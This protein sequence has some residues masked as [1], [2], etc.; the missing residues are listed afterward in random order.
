MDIYAC[1]VSERGTV[2]SISSCLRT[3]LKAQCAGAIDWR[4]DL[5]HRPVKSMHRPLYVRIPA[6]SL[7]ST[8][9]LIN[10][11]VILRTYSFNVNLHVLFPF[12]GTSNC[13]P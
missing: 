2:P 13:V 9:I 1:V 3:P 10:L 5:P 6:Q 11:E 7:C 4:S 12:M 8:A